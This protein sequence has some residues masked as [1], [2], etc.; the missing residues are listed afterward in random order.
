VFGPLI[1]VLAVIVATIFV[2][3]ASLMVR[4]HRVA[5]HLAPRFLD[6]LLATPRLVAVRRGSV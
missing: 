1:I 2:F 4:I 6:D 5:D 3:W